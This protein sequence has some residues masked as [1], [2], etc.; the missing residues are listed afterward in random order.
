MT[1]HLKKESREKQRAQYQGQRIRPTNTSLG[2]SEA[3]PFCSDQSCAARNARR[4]TGTPSPGEHVLNIR[5]V[6]LAR[7]RRNRIS[8]EPLDAAK[9]GLLGTGWTNIKLPSQLRPVGTAVDTAPWNNSVP[10]AKNA[11]PQTTVKLF[12]VDSELG[13]ALSSK[14]S[15]LLV[16]YAQPNILPDH[17]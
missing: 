15:R 14:K 9:A 6:P 13:P 8:I 17:F 11:A 1:K 10:L 12:P 3:H 5:F 7:A 4:P 16:F 2:P